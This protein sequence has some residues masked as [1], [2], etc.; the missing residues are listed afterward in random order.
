MLVQGVWA[1]VADEAQ[2]M[3]SQSWVGM[4]LWNMLR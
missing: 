1:H 4:K 2:S 3:E